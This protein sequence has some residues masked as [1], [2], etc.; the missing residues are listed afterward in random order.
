MPVQ[1][2]GGANIARYRGLSTDEKPGR[3]DYTEVGGVGSEFIEVDT[4]VRFVWG[5]AWPWVRK[6]QSIETLINDLTEVNRET[7]AYV[8]A[9]HKGHQEHLWEEEVE[10]DYP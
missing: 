10:V 5:G 6:A 3:F 1:R 9:I 2:D 4:G 7:L 8:K